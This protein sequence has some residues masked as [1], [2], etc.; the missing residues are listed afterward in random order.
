MTVAGPP[1]AHRT[2]SPIE[3]YALLGDLHTAA[4]VGLDGSID[5][6]CVPRFDSSACFAALLGDEAHGRWRIHPVAPV[7]SV[8]RRYRGD[9][10]VLETRFET[11]EGAVDVVDCMALGSDR[12]TVVRCIEG[13][14]GRVRVRMELRLRFDTGL[15]A[16]WVHRIDGRDL[17][18]AGSD[19]AV[20]DSPVETASDGTAVRAELSV[21]PGVTAAFTLVWFPSYAEPPPRPD[22]AQA[23]ADTCRWWREWAGRCTYD[24]EWRDEV[25]RSLLT[26]KALTYDPSGGIAAAPTTSLPEDLGGE[27]NFDYRYCWLRD[28]TF[29]L[30]AL[31]GNGYEREAA[32]WRDW[33]LRVIGGDP[34]QLRTLAGVGGELEIGE[35]TLDWLPGYESSRPVRVGNAAGSQLQLDVYGEVLDVLH[36]ARRRGIGP[37]HHAWEVER[38][39]VE[40]LEGCWREPD[41]GIW[42][43]RG[44]ERRH[45]HSAVMAWVAFDRAIASVERFDLDGPAAALA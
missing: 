19:A 6:L 12:P 30:Y 31:L 2:G 27:R 15:T 4:L 25:V 13:V 28:A 43:I 38:A 18:V 20:L 26:L 14:R 21:E 40:H 10:L 3:H 17:L 8:R 24:G 22:A 9:T 23:L 39:L 35:R 34:S 29:T 16:P 11:D 44:D 32:A 7:R 37:E 41:S 45:T 36:Q 33:L 5:W 1:R 42:E